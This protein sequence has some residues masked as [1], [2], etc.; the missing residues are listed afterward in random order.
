MKLT[1]IFAILCITGLEIV[2]LTTGINGAIF[3]VA[4]AA[5]A[6]LGGYEIKV[7]R[8]KRKGG[9]NAKRKE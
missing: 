2:A 4:I 5:I 1:P 6:G 3:G 9:N 7:L 8:D